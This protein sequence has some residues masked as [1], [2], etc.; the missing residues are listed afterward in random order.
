MGYPEW[1]ARLLPVA[2]GAE[3]IIHSIPFRLASGQFA[4]GLTATYYDAVSTDASLDGDRS[5][6]ADTLAVPRW[7]TWCSAGQPCDYTIDFS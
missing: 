4:G 1:H 5:W 3:S 7:S 6:N 2:D